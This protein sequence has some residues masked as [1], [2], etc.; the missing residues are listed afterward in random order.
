[1]S[2]R[3]KKY[4]FF[5]CIGLLSFS[6]SSSLVTI[7]HAEGSLPFPEIEE[8]EKSGEWVI[9]ESL[10]IPEGHLLTLTPGTDVVFDGENLKLFVVG[11][12]DIR[13]TK[14]HP[15]TIRTKNENDS[16]SIEVSGKI[17]SRHADIADGGRYMPVYLVEN[18]DRKF[19]FFSFVQTAFAN[20][21]VRSGALS[22]GEGA[23]AF[24]RDTVFY[25]NV[26][27]VYC[28]IYAPQHSIENISLL[29]SSF[30]SNEH[31]YIY[32]PD[33][34][35]DA[36]YSWWEGGNSPESEKLEGDIKTEHWRAQEDIR[37]PVILIPGIMGSFEVVY[38]FEQDEENF[39]QVREISQ[40]RRDPAFDTYEDLWSSLQDAGYEEGEDLFDFP[41][42]W[43]KSNVQTA[44]DLEVKIRAIQEQTNWP[45]VDIVAHSMGGLVAREYIQ[46]DREGY[47]DIDQLITMGTPQLGS[48]EA[49]LQWEGGYIFSGFL[50]D[51]LKKFAFRN[52]ARHAGYESVWEYIRNDIPSVGELLPVF[53]YLYDGDDIREY[54]EEYP[55]NLF[56][57]RLQSS[58]GD[59]LREIEFDRIMGGFGDSPSTI[60][61]L[62]VTKKD[63][64]D[65]WEYGYPDDIE[66]EGD[67]CN[68]LF[69]GN[70]DETVPLNSAR[71]SELPVNALVTIPNGSH[72]NLPSLAREEVV[73]LLTGKTPQES[74]ESSWVDSFL[75]FFAFSPVDFFVQAPDGKKIGKN[76][77]TNEHYT[78]IEG[79][80]YTGYDTES[81]FIIIPRPLE[82]EYRVVL[83][84]T[85][86]G[87]YAMESVLADESGGESVVR[88]EGSAQTDQEESLL[89][90]VTQDTVDIPLDESVEENVSRDDSGEVQETE[91]G[92]EDENDNKEDE[93]EDEDED[94]NE[95]E[96]ERDDYEEE[97]DSLPLFVSNMRTSMASLANEDKEEKR[98]DLEASLTVEEEKEIPSFYPNET[99]KGKEYSLW[100]GLA[101][102]TF[103]FFLVWNV[104]VKRKRIRGWYVKGCNWLNKRKKSS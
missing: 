72:G 74:E 56:L 38:D 54:P 59:R 15:V 49:Y 17:F 80:Y 3:L 46:Q 67:E 52:W 25:D 41:Y 66:E 102:G 78:E 71:A 11:T 31:E 104:Y 94:E 14:E 83:R 82:G 20:V 61:G 22:F 101:L 43:K 100:R 62:S 7:L 87:T 19:R 90:S 39:G 70:G 58:S 1:M 12:L 98:D 30:S 81:E 99:T 97:S 27:A 45:W 13:G 69:E 84:G 89:F 10:I 53:D 96:D 79:A 47:S 68:C 60:I 6:F 18:S 28:D 29:R 64:K 35:I 42:D 75:G 2:S 48:P 55:R 65:L 36:Q 24:M 5:L 73:G 50:M 40:W 34:T 86:T 37:D 88:Y 44:Q 26:V 33:R 23:E 32:C 4:I 9:S 85:D 95:D 63:D 51:T 103:I 93:N 77:Q 21:I 8:S 57:E 92:N 91:G 16:Y 76:F